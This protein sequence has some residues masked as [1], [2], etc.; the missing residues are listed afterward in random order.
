MHVYC[1][2]VVYKRD[3]NFDVCL[4][5]IGIKDVWNVVPNLHIGYQF[6][7]KFNILFVERINVNVFCKNSLFII[8]MNS[9][10]IKLCI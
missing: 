1:G 4:V 8:C 5:D 9:M 10:Q 3:N 2:L 7:F 6:F